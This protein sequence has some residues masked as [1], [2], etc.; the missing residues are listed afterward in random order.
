MRFVF[1]GGIVGRP[2]DEISLG[3]FSRQL[4]IGELCS[5]RIVRIFRVASGRG[6]FHIQASDIYEKGR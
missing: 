1:R 3:V 5:R 6:G 2:N 4:S